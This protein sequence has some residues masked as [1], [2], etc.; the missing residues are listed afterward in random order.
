MSKFPLIVH[1]ADGREI[2]VFETQE[3][4][5]EFMEGVRARNMSNAYEIVRF[6]NKLH[7][8]DIRR[9]S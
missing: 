6:G 1:A 2:V 4:A 9:L 5:D 3:E 8:L 7:P